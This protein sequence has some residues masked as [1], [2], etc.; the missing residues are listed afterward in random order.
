MPEELSFRDRLEI[1]VLTFCLLLS[2][3]RVKVYLVIKM[4]PTDIIDTHP[5]RV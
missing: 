5:V 1:L 4:I 2:F 3:S